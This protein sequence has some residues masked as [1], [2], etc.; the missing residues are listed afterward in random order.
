MTKL[1]KY[2]SKA[3]L[4]H[5]RIKYN[6]EVFKFNLFEELQ[7]VETKKNDQIKEHAQ[8]AAFLLMLLKKFE[9]LVKDLDKERKKVKA[10]RL[11][12][13]RETSESVKVA[14]IR[15]DSDKK[16]ITAV[17]ALLEVEEVKGVLEAC[18]TSFNDRKELLQTLSANVRKEI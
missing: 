3:K 16:Y 8:S 14:E 11:I 13:L 17:D 4:M 18:V 7:I 12:K 5:I 2:A 10:T 9:I 15:I 1:N 6:D